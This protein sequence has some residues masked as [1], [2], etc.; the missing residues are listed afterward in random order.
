M[1]FRVAVLLGF[2]SLRP[3]RITG[4]MPCASVADLR[5]CLLADAAAW[6]R[7]HWRG[8]SYYRWSATRILIRLGRACSTLVGLY[9]DDF[10]PFWENG[11]LPPVIVPHF[12]VQESTCTPESKSVRTIIVRLVILSTIRARSDWKSPR[13]GTINVIYHDDDGFRC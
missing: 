7:L 11:H 8:L 9:A 5:G 2:L 6:R 3:A 12:A 10:G 13:L 4:R 1:A